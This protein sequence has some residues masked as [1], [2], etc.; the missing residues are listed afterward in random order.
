MKITRFPSRATTDEH[1]TTYTP[2]IDQRGR[3]GYICTH[4]SV[5]T[6]AYLYF[7]PSS[8]DD[9]YDQPLS[10]VF[11]YLGLTG[12]PAVDEPGNHYG[13]FRHFREGS[14]DDYANFRTVL[15]FADDPED[16]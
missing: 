5:E 7:N 15:E 1:G 9:D 2:Y 3:A 14:D 11:V 4:P 6:P 8:E 12:D 16:E 13:V 10:N